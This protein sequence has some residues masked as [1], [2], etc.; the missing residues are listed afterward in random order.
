P[1]VERNSNIKE[2]IDRNGSSSK[3]E[4]V[5]AIKA[6]DRSVVGYVTAGIVAIGALISLNARRKNRKK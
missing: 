3:K 1:Y 5:E 2:N 6:G 4:I